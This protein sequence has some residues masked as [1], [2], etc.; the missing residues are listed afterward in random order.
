MSEKLKKL[1][2]TAPATG[3]QPID[4]ESLHIEKPGLGIWVSLGI[5]LPL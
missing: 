4:I 3:P 5:A 1:M 2:I